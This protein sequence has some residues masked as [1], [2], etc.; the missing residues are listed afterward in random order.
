MRDLAQRPKKK[1]EALKHTA[2]PWMKK[3]VSE[4]ETSQLANKYLSYK[5]T[6]QMELDP[7]IYNK[8]FL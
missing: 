8:M 7:Y 5:L 1:I 3:F 6:L 2:H 4:N